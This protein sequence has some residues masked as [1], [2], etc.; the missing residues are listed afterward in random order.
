MPYRGYIRRTERR[1]EGETKFEKYEDILIRVD[2]FD[3]ISASTIAAMC[4]GERAMKFSGHKIGTIR[5]TRKE[6]V[7][8]YYNQLSKASKKLKKAWSKEEMFK[9]AVTQETDDYRERNFQRRNFGDFMQ[10]YYYGFAK[11]IEDYEMRAYRAELKE[12][13]LL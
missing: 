9:Q 2:G 13:G 3:R 12:K 6:A 8:D 1:L 4:T 5:K 7:L 11:K 10:R